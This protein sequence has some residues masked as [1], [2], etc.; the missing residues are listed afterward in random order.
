MTLNTMKTAYCTAYGSPDVIDIRDLPKP[1]PKPNEILVKIVA[2]SVTR[3]DSLMRQGI[4]RFGRLFLGLFKPKNP[5]MGTGFA[6]KIVQVGA[7]VTLF[8]IGD[9]VF[10][11]TIF[12]SGANAE[13]VAIEES[14]IVLK[15]PE[16]ISFKEAS[17]ICDGPLTSYSIL[18]DIGELKKGQHVLI[19]GA[20]G[21]LG[22]A[23]VQIAKQ[24]GAD[25]V[26]VCST[27]NIT[28][29]KALGADEVID[30]KTTDF[31][32]LN[33]R[34][35]IVY[36]TVGKSSYRSSK[37]ILKDEGQYLSPVLTL[38]LLWNSLLSSICYKKK[39][40]FS[41]TG[42]RPTDVLS[43]LVNQLK[44]MLIND[45]LNIIIDK[46]FALNEISK[47]HEYIDTGR[48]RGNVVISMESY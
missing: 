26:G 3:A 13:F 37:S 14:K 12:G 4:P 7:D 1:I 8:K 39:A 31:T 25:V 2:S 36:D 44:G 38:P 20:S 15:K 48:K 46:T 43:P 6:G 35:D 24:M 30:Y 32:R 16:C 11:E 41:A 22:T 47:A 28:M 29:V 40:K 34:F 23:A 45:E 21:S 10:G 18:K 33:H 42:M 9:E 19:N 27:N 17:T 5:G